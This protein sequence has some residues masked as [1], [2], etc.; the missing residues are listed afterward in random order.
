MSC[1]CVVHF[2]IPTIVGRFCRMYTESKSPWNATDC[3][4]TVV[5]RAPPAHRV[6]GGIRIG[7]SLNRTSRKQLSDSSSGLD[8]HTTMT[9]AEA[10]N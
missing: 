8:L 10:G 3:I 1:V 4:Q 9:F 2:L 6:A 7:I 5:S